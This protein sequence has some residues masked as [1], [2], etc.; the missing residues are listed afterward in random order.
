M[1]IGRTEPLTLMQENRALSLDE[2]ASMSYDRG[3]L[4]PPSAAIAPSTV[5]NNAIRAHIKRCEISTPPRQPLLSKYQLAG[6]INEAVLESALH[7]GA[8]HGSIRPKGTVWYLVPAGKAKWRNPFEGLEMPKPPPRKPVVNSKSS[9]DSK[10]KVDKKSKSKAT[11]NGPLKIRLLVNRGACAPTQEDDGSE[12]GSSSRSSRSGS[13]S[14]S[15]GTPMNIQSLSL[16]PKPRSSGRMMGALDSSSDS[17]SSDS[18]LAHGNQQAIEPRKQSRTSR[19]PPPPPL[20][21]PNP[22]RLT[23]L[24]HRTASS[25][26]ADLFFPSAS[27]PVLAGVTP[28]LQHVHSHSSPF[29]SHSLDNTTWAVRHD[30]ERSASYE[31]S[32][33]SS[34][35]EMREPEWGVSSSI[36]VRGED[37]DTKPVWTAEDEES[38]V[39]EATDA[40]RVL[41]P[42]ASPEEEEDM[43]EAPFELTRLDN[44][45]APSDTSSLAE[46]SST[47]TAQATSRGQLRIPDLSGSIAL[48]AW[49]ASSSPVPSPN[50]RPLA[51][52]APDISPIQHLSKLRSS[53]DPNDMDIDDDK[54]WLDESG[55][56]PVKAEDT[57]S[58]I[59]LGSTIGD[60][61]TPEHD[62]Q[63]HTAAWAREAAA[64]SIRMADGSE[65]YPSPSMTEP[66][67]HIASEPRDSRASSTPSTESSELTPFDIES[68]KTF[69]PNVDEVIVGPESI[70]LDEIDG[71]L[72]TTTGKPDRTPQRSRQYKSKQQPHRCSGN[73]GYIGVGSQL[74]GNVGK[75]TPLTKLSNKA[76]N[77]RARS[78][79]SSSRRR[80]SVMRDNSLPTPPRTDE[81]DVGAESESVETPDAIGTAD[82]ERARAD[83]EAKEEQ[84]RR[85]FQEKSD[86]QKALLEAYRQKVREDNVVT[87]P[88][89]LPTTWAS[90][91]S[92]PWPDL[93]CTPWGSSESI[94]IT[95]PSALSPLAL[96]CLSSL[97]LGNESS[98]FPSALDPKLLLSP[99][100]PL[101]H[102]TS[103]LDEVLSQA[104]VEAVMTT[105]EASPPPL[106]PIA[107]SISARPTTT[108]PVSSDKVKRRTTSIADDVNQPSQA[109][110]ESESTESARRLLAPPLTSKAQANIT[111]RLCPGVDATV[112]DNIPVFS[113]V[114]DTKLGKVIVLRR[115][116]TDFG[117]SMLCSSTTVY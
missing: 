35:D 16:K 89:S 79:R 62:R 57:F 99:P 11:L 61:S 46:S 112:V 13:R 58:D 51:N 108:S 111:K 55:E 56:L 30:H 32:S 4:R 72:S 95:S 100:L 36:L 45:P 33:S 114:S 68:E 9:K 73:W 87:P 88:D 93:S 39:K 96:N 86:R 1:R 54:Q 10:G 103:N 82:L 77:A 115:M 84:Y 59:D 53:L 19:K 26:F 107:S 67:E 8:F 38:K 41:F 116:D 44:R 12:D 109:Q 66:E 2:I 52:L 76:I 17:D 85:A 5:I 94:N 20:S 42:L 28:Y 29:P 69:K 98:P 7:P 14:R 48:S 92:S 23:H 104:E 15:S 25:P 117:E 101:N 34:D 78:V 24:P 90:M 102:P 49:T 21:I 43:M 60:A 22:A 27:S 50:L 18:E 80:R 91:D 110:E 40:L 97:S 75:P 71:W 37:G 106:E 105:I 3:W 113:H 65:D 64:T 6:S 31:T 81:P 83:A 47:A 74:G 70:T 63:L